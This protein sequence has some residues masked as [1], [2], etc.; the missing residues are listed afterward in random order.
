MDG[1]THCTRTTWSTAGRLL[2]ASTYNMAAKVVEDAAA[3]GNVEEGTSTENKN[4]RFRKEKRACKASLMHG[5][6]V[7][8]HVYPVALL[9][10]W[11][12]DDV[13]HWDIVKIGPEDG[14]K[15][16]AQESSFATLFPKYREPYLKS[17]WELVTKALEKHVSA[18]QQ[19]AGR[20]L[21]C[22]SMTGRWMHTGSC[23]R[24]Y[25]CPDN[26]ADV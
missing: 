4:K 24:Q 8:D 25:D 16:F 19:E 9:A 12:T 11:D 10:A 3:N 17:I 26:T 22:A 1:H 14:V 15:P 20:M 23:G 21:N 6:C 5:V 2:P 13:N 18:D 7:V